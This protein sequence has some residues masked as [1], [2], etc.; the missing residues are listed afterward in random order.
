MYAD[1]A[2]LGVDQNSIRYYDILRAPEPGSTPLPS[3]PS[4]FTQRTYEWRIIDFDGAY[5]SNRCASLF[6]G[7]NGGYLHR[8][9]HNLP[10]GDIWE[11]WH[12]A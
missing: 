4:P 5:K 6:A 1:L 10:W 12:S 7:R 11:P 3:L 9:L 2:R 8:L